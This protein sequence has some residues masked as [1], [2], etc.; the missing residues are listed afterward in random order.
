M[1]RPHFVR[2]ALLALCVSACGGSATEV[3][4]GEPAVLTG[5]FTGRFTSEDQGI[6]SMQR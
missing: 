6:I 1:P 4:P 2:S 3:V 5:E